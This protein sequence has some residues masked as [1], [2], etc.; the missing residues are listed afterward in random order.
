MWFIYP[1][2]AVSFI[3]VMVG[4]SGKKDEPNDLIVKIT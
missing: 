3:L 2:I 4:A 1:P